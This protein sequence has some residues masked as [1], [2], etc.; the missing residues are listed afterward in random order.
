M[1]R[2]SESGGNAGNWGQRTSG[3]DSTIREFSDSDSSQIINSLVQFVERLPRAS[4]VST[5]QRSA[6][7]QSVDSMQREFDQLIEVQ[8]GSER[9][10]VVLEY[11]LPME[12]R[13]PDCIVLMNEA[14]AVIEFKSGNHA[15]DAAVDQ[16]DAYA[17]DLGH[18]HRECH[19]RAIH[20]ILVPMRMGGKRYQSGTVAVCGP[21]QL[22]GL[23]LELDKGGSDIPPVDRKEFLR[24]DAYRPLPSLITAARE[25]FNSRAVRRL[26]KSIVDTEEAKDYVL[27]VIHEAQATG[28]HRLVLLT[29]VPGAGKTLVGLRV[30]HEP[31][32]DDLKDQDS[33]L[34]AVFLSGNDPLVDVLQHEL[35]EAGGN[36]RTFVR[37]V[38]KYR[39]HYAHDPSMVPQE[40]VV[41]FDEAQRAWD[42]GRLQLAN[43]NHQQE[44]RTEPGHLIEFANRK[45]DWAVVLG[46]IGTDQVIQPGEEGGLQLWQAALAEHETDNHLWVVHGPPELAQVFGRGTVEFKSSAS[47]RLEHSVRSHLSHKLHKFVDELLDLADSSV[48]K[49]FLL[50]VSERR[51]HF[52]LT[53]NLPAAESYLR[54]RYDGNFDARYGKVVS[55]RAKNMGQY[56]FP[57]EWEAMGRVKY[58]IGKWYGNERGEDIS[59]CNL[60]TCATEFESQGLELDATLM[61]WG[62]D[63]LYGTTNWDNSRARGYSKKYEDLV[64]DKLMLRKNAYRVLL[65][66]ARDACVIYVP[67]IYESG[68]DIMLG[69]YE[70]LR[71]LGLRELSTEDAQ[72]RPT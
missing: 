34:P 40:H 8:I 25:L 14:L 24:N 50:E 2:E 41:V 5:S 21:D 62:P 66:R 32:L 58:N 12:Y 71:S 56:G 17:R 53:R 18:Y 70:H 6:W 7:K 68:E 16:V 51:F 4:G 38:Q 60:D 61:C 72:V 55:A 46:L 13:R 43:N 10:G 33:G 49:E 69:T 65:T 37:S 28:T 54:E 59:C 22:D 39:D 15:T 35:K 47:L 67:E 45:R 42:I 52:R 1:S 29:G 23:I 48:L 44:L 27:S 26:W 64:R 19:G 30:V 9:Y 3:W 63:L 31:G 57:N 20:P 11:Q 36:G